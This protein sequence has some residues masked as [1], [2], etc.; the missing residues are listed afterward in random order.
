MLWRPIFMAFSRSSVEVAA[1]PLAQ[2]TDMAR[3]SARSASNSLGLAMDGVLQIMDQSV[4][5]YVR[6]NTLAPRS[7]P[8]Y[9]A[10]PGRE[11]VD[12]PA[13]VAELADAPDSKSGSERSVGS[14]PT[15][16]TS[17]RA[18]GASARRAR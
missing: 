7:R 3:F 13:G 12:S 14:T 4:K 6:A 17:L 8:F 2:N 11:P 10:A 15:A 18:T 5:N 9:K 1:Y 16:R